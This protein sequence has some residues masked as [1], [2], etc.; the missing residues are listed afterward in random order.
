MWHWREC[1][2]GGGVW[3][4]HMWYD[5][6]ICDMTH[7][8]VTWPIHMWHDS[9]ICD[10]TYSYVTWLIHTWHDS[11]ICDM[12]HSYVTWL[13]HIW[14][15]SFICDMTHSYMTWLIYMLH[16]SFICDK[17]HSY[18]TCHTY[19]WVMS[20]ISMSHVTRIDDSYEYLPTR[21]RRHFRRA[22]IWCVRGCWGT[23]HIHKWM[24]HVEYECVTSY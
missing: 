6:C 5:P 13:I 21:W 4:F 2:C 10:M 19:K 16:N 12:T 15:D 18:L 23:S 9:F 3:L 24:S 8:Y 14:H 20:H 11:F 1:V 7:S 22:S 17:T